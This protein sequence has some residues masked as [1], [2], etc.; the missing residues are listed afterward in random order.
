LNGQQV[1]LG[2]E[3]T[4]PEK[5]PEV[6]LL[7][8]R[9]SILDVSDTGWQPMS[10]VDGRY[11]LIFNGEI[12]NYLEIR[13][14][15]DEMGHRFRSGSDTEVLL[16]AFVQWGT[17]ALPRLVGMF[18]FALL[19]TH[20]RTLLL[21]RDFFGIKPLFYW[22]DSGR[23]FFASEIKALT[24]FGL[25]QP[26]ANAERLLLYLRY[27]TT[28][29]GSE[30]MLS[31]VRQIPPAHF[32]EISVDGCAAREPRRYW[33]AESG[34]TLDISLDDAAAQV[35]DLFLRN[36]EIHLRS[37]VPVG[38]ALSGGIDSSAIVMGIRRLDPKAEI[39]A[40][41]YI[42]EDATSSEEKW[43]DMVAREARVHVHKVRA[44][45]EELAQDLDAMVRLQDEPFGSTSIYAQNRVFRSARAA[46][47]KVML[48][49]QGADEILGGYNSYKGARLASLLRQGRWS[50]AAGFLGRLSGNGGI[51]LYLGAAYSANYIL[52]PAMQSIVR[53]LA[54]KDA[55]PAWLNRAWFAERG[56]GAEFAGYTD[57]KDVLR[58]TLKRA[59]SRTL[60]GLLRYED[61]NSMASS[62]ESRVP[63]LTPNLVG[64]L[65]VLP[66][67]CLIDLEGTTKSVFRK[68]MRGIVP[69]AILDRRDKVG[70]ATPEKRWLTQLDGW[71]RSVLDGEVAATLPFLNMGAVRREFEAVC[72]GRRPFGFHIWRWVNLIRWTENL[73]VFYE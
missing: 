59:V 21:A 6:L 13:R 22:K 19:D 67:N 14:E 40:F 56:V 7:H 20:R 61:R 49:G 18:A 36:V 73:Q 54:R 62:V 48:D 41:S 50:Q 35:R 32:M 66:E 57:A 44:S 63:F 72:Q 37:D 51:G 24:A 28:D 29:F 25:S 38:V 42:S 4:V 52:P 30:T 55:F 5:E 26:R 15:L 33:T 3:W 9:L 47:V 46:G 68:A 23:I 12:Y 2:R 31:E 45:A 65:G 53:I 11:R 17:A 70:F 34:E 43:I 64:F 69:D 8:R 1:E 39:H 58:E 10:T 60:P 71:V 16:N 27:G